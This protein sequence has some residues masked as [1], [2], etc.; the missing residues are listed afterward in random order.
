MLL[1]LFRGFIVERNLLASTE[2]DGFGRGDGK[3]EES[4]TLVRYT[5]LLHWFAAC[6]SC[7]TSLMVAGKEDCS[8]TPIIALRQVSQH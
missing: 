5:E 7:C 6:G 1:R 8:K 4:T 2:T 3:L